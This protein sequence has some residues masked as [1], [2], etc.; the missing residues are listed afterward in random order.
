[1][2]TR[3]EKKTETRGRLLEATRRVVAR[4]GYDG[5][6][7]D[8]IAEEAGLTSGA[9]YSNFKGK[10]ELFSELVRTELDAQISALKG[11]LSQHVPVAER[12]RASAELWMSFIEREPEVLMLTAEAW[13]RAVRDP[14]LRPEF[15][16]HFR[17]VRASLT[18][19]ISRMAHETGLR[20]TMPAEQLAIVF[21]ALADG[22]SHQ[23]LVDPDAVPDE[24]LGN[25]ISLLLGAGS[26]VNGSA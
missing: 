19:L 6:S 13:A 8:E 17:E 7:V 5:A 18:R 4:H 24:L 14:E 1:M 22:I 21:D 12:A 15:A 10:E 23:K 3:E 16:E 11:A 25:V 26:E 2:A 20:L 9:V